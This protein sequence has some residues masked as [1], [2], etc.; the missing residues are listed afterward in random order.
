MVGRKTSAFLAIA[1]VSGAVLVCQG[2]RT[3]RRNR[4][5]RNIREYMERGLLL[6]KEKVYGEAA[7]SY[8]K[9]L[10]LMEEEDG[11]LVSVY[12]NLAICLA[13]VRAYK[14][15]AL[16]AER[17]LKINILDNEKAL[18]LRYECHKAL[19]MRRETLCDAF[20]C[21]LVTK[22]EKYRKLAQEILKLE[23]EG[24]AKKM[25]GVKE[26][27]PSSISYENFFG[28]FPD[29]FG[30]ESFVNDELVRLVRS[31]KYDEAFEKA[32]KRDDSISKF[33]AAGV[34]H[35]RGKDLSSISLLEHEKMIFSI[36]LREYLKSLHGH[37]PMDIEDFVLKNS[38]SVSVLFYASK[39]HL[40]LK[41][42]ELY[43]KF[44]DMA[45]ECEEHDFLY[46]DRIIYE[47]GHGR[48]ERAQEFLNKA[49]ESH[50]LSI[51]VLSI[52]CE[53]YLRCKDMTRLE[54]TMSNFEKYY[55]EDPRF[56]LFKGIVAQAR[57]EVSDAERY[58]RLAIE[59]DSKFFKPYVYLGGIL[60]GRNDKSCREVYEEALKC[61]ASYDELFLVEQALILIDVQEKIIRIYPD[62]LKAF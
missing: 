55:H 56:L 4:R 31:G 39:I 24:E 13:K 11:R 27:S 12:N 40:N 25:A 44:I 10:S 54:T 18:R 5:E 23:A 51:H 48:N 15:A 16:Y 22:D 47:V 20:L 37:T 42:H 53:Y 28:T 36:C 30:N 2:V 7:L 33:V 8:L 60:L 58:F 46:V 52:A 9:C 62:V 6:L 50:P 59:A 49:L 21:G 32:E 35:V 3:W 41:N 29:L 17:S 19:D 1:I 45:M 14:E 34:I 61:A 26:A 43:E 38:K 57:N